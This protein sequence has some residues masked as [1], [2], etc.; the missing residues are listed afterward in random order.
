MAMDELKAI[1]AR[2]MN[3]DEFKR[4]LMENP[5]EAVKEGGF[6]LSPEEIETLKTDKMLGQIKDEVL[7]RRDSKGMFRI[8]T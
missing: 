5:E 6:N 4:L 8:G 1:I 7:E 3:D 2:A